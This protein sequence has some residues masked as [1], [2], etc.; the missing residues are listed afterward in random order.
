MGS[1]ELR[2]SAATY[3]VVHWLSRHSLWDVGALFHR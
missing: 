2:V 3:Q 1:F